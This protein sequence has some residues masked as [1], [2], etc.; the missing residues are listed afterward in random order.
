MAELA[1]LFTTTTPGGTISQRNV[2]AGTGFDVCLDA[3]AESGEFALGAQFSIGA[4]LN[5]ITTAAAPLLLTPVAPTPAYGAVANMN[6]AAWPAIA[7]QFRWTVPAGVGAAN[8]ILEIRAFVTVGAGASVEAD[9]AT[10]A[11]IRK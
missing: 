8:N 1:R 5:N 4:V 11:L 3:E 7:N 9:F 2:P 10:T 6:T